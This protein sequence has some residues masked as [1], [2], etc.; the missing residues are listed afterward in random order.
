MRFGL[1]D[2]EI[3]SILD[4][5]EKNLG[6]TSNPQVFIYGSRVKGTHRK[7]SDIDIL[8]CASELDRN[9]L[10]RVDF[11]ALDIPY[12]VDFVL[13]PDLYS[14]YREEISSHMKEFCR[15]LET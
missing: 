12:K 15:A 14:E 10:S 2:S 4:E 8:L 3:H 13:E 6:E 5:I 11:Q 7:F 1:T 9:S